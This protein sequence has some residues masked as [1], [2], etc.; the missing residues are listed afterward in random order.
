MGH[1]SMSAARIW[2]GVSNLWTYLEPQGAVPQALTLLGGIRFIAWR[3]RRHCLEECRRGSRHFGECPVACGLRPCAQT[4]LKK[5]LCH[6]RP[7]GGTADKYC[8]RLNGTTTVIYKDGF[9]IRQ[10][11]KFLIKQRNQTRN[12]DPKMGPWQSHLFAQLYGFKYL[13]TIFSKQ[14]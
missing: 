7:V 14:L 13:I 1:T 4:H 3:L 8:C 12:L 11:V 5:T 9:N 2:S 6:T 10:P